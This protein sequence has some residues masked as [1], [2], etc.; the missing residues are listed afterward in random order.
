MIKDGYINCYKESHAQPV[1]SLSI[2]EY[3]GDEDVLKNTY[4]A[5]T[6]VTCLCLPHSDYIQ[7]FGVTPRSNQDKFMNHAE[8]DDFEVVRVL[9][10]GNFSTVKLAKY[11]Y[12]NNSSNGRGNDNTLFALKCFKS[13]ATD[14]PRTVKEV[15]ANEKRITS[16]LESQFIVQFFGTI[17]SNN[18]LYFILEAMLGGDLYSL[19]DKKRKFNED[20]MRFYA[21]SVACAFKDIH[22]HNIAYR[23]L[24]P[25]NLILT[26]E[27][28]IKIVDFGLAK[29]LDG[30]EKTYTCC[31]TVS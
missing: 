31:G 22:A 27:G 25:E 8:I 24:K 11:K 10:T 1:N 2:G 29:K 9:G 21:A 18:K 17:K 30:D 20:W 14:D 7:I 6:S 19:L 15:I 26:N 5:T 12:P 13:S 23:D 16:Q 28:H 4:I 3:F